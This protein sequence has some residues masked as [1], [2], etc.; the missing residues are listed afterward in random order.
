M[1]DILLAARKT[2]GSAVPEAPIERI[3]LSVLNS[4]N[5]SHSR[6]VSRTV[7]SPFSRGARCSPRPRRT[8]RKCDSR[9]CV[10]SRILGG[11]H[12]P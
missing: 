8:R 11:C 7:L 5:S 1:T 2:D 10:Q 12:E 3:K 6:R 4:L 9:L